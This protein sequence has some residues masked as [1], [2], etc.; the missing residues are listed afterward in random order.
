MSARGR[1]L[2]ALDEDLAV[3]PIAA[4]GLAIAELLEADTSALHVGGTVPLLAGRVCDELHVRLTVR[5]GRVVPVLRSEMDADD[6]V[7][8]VVGMRS[9]PTGR[10]PGGRT[11]IRL[12]TS[13]RKAL[14]VVPPDLASS[15]TLRRI[16]VP[17]NGA[18]S[19]PVRQIISRASELAL[20]TMILHVHDETSIPLFEDQ[21]QHEGEAW[22]EEFIARNDGTDR[23]NVT[24]RVG[25]P[26]VEIERFVGTEHPD[27]IVLAWS[28]DLSSGRAEVVRAS[29]EQLRV[30][31][32]LV[33]LP[34][35]GRRVRPRPSW[36]V[37]V[38]GPDPRPAR[39]PEALPL[40]S[41]HDVLPSNDRRIHPAP[42]SPEDEGPRGG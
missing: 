37:G 5:R 10:R 6:V 28:Q 15:W 13:A 4:V 26:A 30:P 35:S 25:D 41:G 2:I 22:T 19:S 8:S 29:M 14:V 32:M 18:L 24:I 39:S 9:R 36:G 40:A 27:F 23:G 38:R 17:I 1:V 16:L 21:R 7:A 34:A 11:T 12:M 42:T 33:P 3:R 20:G 31:V